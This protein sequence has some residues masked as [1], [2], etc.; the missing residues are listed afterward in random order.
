M[1]R[2]LMTPQS[3]GYLAGEAPTW[4]YV[5]EP[6]RGTK[7]SLLTKGGVQVVGEFTGKLGENY[8]GWAKLIKR[9]KEIERKLGYGLQL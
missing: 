2:M 5:Q 4:E 3:S 8:I 6:P 7:L 1:L 9:D